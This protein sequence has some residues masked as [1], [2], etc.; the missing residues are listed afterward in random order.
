MKGFDSDEEKPETCP[1]GHRADDA[2]LTSAPAP[3]VVAAE[4]ETAAVE[5]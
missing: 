2:E 4:R 1:Q 5:A 3:E